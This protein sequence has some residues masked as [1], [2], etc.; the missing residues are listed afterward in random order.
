MVQKHEESDRYFDSHFKNI[1]L[2]NM[3]KP[4][5]LAFFARFRDVPNKKS[6]TRILRHQISQHNKEKGILTSVLI[7]SSFLDK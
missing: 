6:S 1:F 4:A 5:I 2:K 3:V 7:K